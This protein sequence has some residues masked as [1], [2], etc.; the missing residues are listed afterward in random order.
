M[1]SFL[2]RRFTH[3]IEFSRAGHLRLADATGA[4]KHVAGLKKHPIS[5]PGCAPTPYAQG[6]V[7]VRLTEGESTPERTQGLF[8]A[9]MYVDSSVSA[10]S[11]YN[12]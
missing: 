6:S 5:Y 7:P 9:N 4:T 12:P 2:G 8:H 3:T 11:I 10:E 1:R